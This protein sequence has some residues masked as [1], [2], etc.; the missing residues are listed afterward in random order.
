MDKAFVAA[1]MKKE[2]RASPQTP[3]LRS[4]SREKMQILKNSSVE[5]P[6][7]LEP[8]LPPDLIV[9][10]EYAQNKIKMKVGRRSK[11][12]G[13]ED[14]RVP[15]GDMPPRL[16][17]PPLHPDSVADDN[18]GGGSGNINEQNSHNV[19]QRDGNEESDIF[20]ASTVEDLGSETH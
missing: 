8:P 3:Q 18:G 7:V 14:T 10:S 4:D 12:P 13:V 19:A 11:Q 6:P 20:R 1:E 9:D 17:P 5:I 15:S 2:E 16:S